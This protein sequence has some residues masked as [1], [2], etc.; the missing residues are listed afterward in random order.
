MK[1]N[2]YILIVFILLIPLAGEFKFF[3]FNN[4]FRI[5]MGTTIFFFFLLWTRKMPII[6]P[7]VII[8]VVIVIFRIFLDFNSGQ[9][10]Q[11][12]TSFRTNFPSFFYYF[13]YAFLFYYFKVKNFQHRLSIIIGLATLIEICSNIVELTLRH[14]ILDNTINIIMIIQIVLL[15]L[16]RS[17]FVL[18]IFSMLK[19]HEAELEVKHKQ[20]QNA[21]MISL[22]SNLYEE[23][24]E[25]KKS[26]QDAEN[27][28][29]NC[30]NLYR[31]MQNEN[32]KLNKNDLSK[33]ILVIAGE[34]HDIKKDNQRIYSGISKMISNE[35]STD[36]MDINEIV[37]IIVNSNR[38]YA[39]ALNKSINFNIYIKNNMPML[40]VYT[41][42]SLMNNL[43]SNSVEAIKDHGIINITILKNE[44]FAVF[45]VQDNGGG[46]PKRKLDLIFKPGYTTKYDDAGNSSTGMGLPYVK[47][48][49][50][51]LGGSIEIDT[52]TDTKITSFI[53]K[54]PV[55]N[56]IER[57]I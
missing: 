5:S 6:V 53:L 46:I 31:D 30:Y 1:K 44:N 29:R 27:I 45:E 23:S 43:V 11:I 2:F 32:L 9:N 51:N 39:Y 54:L 25:L 35:N 21:H 38:K 14:I 10:F 49:V 19:L 7:T 24:V 52:S 20:E 12:I 50:E 34:I 41:T 16:I 18:G 15:A 56:L 37:N 33:K 36:Y 13:T 8:G 57:M 17:I 22:I 42:L 40:H 4:S 48:L 47:N 3:P 26:L 55:K 28:T